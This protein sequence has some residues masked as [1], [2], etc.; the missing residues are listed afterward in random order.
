MWVDQLLN[1]GH[2]AVSFIAI[3]SVI[4]FIHEYGHFLV[5]RLCGVRVEMFSIGFGPE[6]FGWTSRRSGTRWKVS[7]LPFGGYVQ[8]F[9]DAGAASTPDEAAE[10]M[11]EEDKPYSFHYQPLWK[12]AA[13]VVAGPL[14][15]FLLTI[16]VLTGLIF[17]S[18]VSD[19]API[20]GSVI[21]GSAA[22][23]AGLQP[24]DRILSID[25]NEI[26]QFSD[27][28][29]HID[30]N[31]GTPV[32]LTLKRDGKQRSLVL[33]PKMHEE[34]DA[35]GNPVERPRIGIG[36]QKLQYHDVGVFGAVQEATKRTWQ[37]CATTLRAVGQI[38]TGERSPKE[39]KGPLGIAQFSGQATQQDVLTVLWFI[40]ILSAN[41][42]LVNLL[43]IPLLDGGHLMYYAVEAVRG[44]PM[45]MRYQQWGFRIGG[46]L[47]LLLMGGAL[48]NDIRQIW[49]S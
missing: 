38:L 14:A 11:A 39:L 36:S 31:L 8:M 25:G 18:H 17:N 4:V 30:T 13:I 42:G 37:I 44:K 26:Q 15:N 19:V 9:G 1:F 41:L 48:F 2:Y 5:A 27:I 12:K 46:A 28:T 33:T 45:A 10:A 24:G 23:E 47:L 34:K 3:I 7:V 35:L 29:Y 20:V 22:E 21:E 6:I 43:P 16:G 32:T 49:W 40:A